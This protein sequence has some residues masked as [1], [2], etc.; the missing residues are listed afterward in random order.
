L[1][2]NPVKAIPESKI[3]ARFWIVGILLALVTIALLKVR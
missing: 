2:K 1:I 3:V